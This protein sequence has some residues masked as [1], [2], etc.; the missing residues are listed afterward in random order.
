MLLLL[1]PVIKGW[2]GEAKFNAT[3]LA[4]AVPRLWPRRTIWDGGICAT[5]I[6]Q[7]AT[8]VPSVIRPVSLGEPVE[9]PKPR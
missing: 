1:G 9:W 4:I 7:S 3:A 2:A 6:T 8:A 5:C